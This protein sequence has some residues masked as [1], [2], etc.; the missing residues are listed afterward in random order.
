[1]FQYHSNF[2]CMQLI[3]STL[4]PFKKNTH[5]CTAVTHLQAQLL[6]S[7]LHGLAR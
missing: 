5:T 6:F 2:Q 3:E 1:M 7:V 4:I